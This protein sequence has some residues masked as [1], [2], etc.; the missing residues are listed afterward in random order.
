MKILLLSNKSPWPPKDG[1]SAA[2][3]SM[4]MALSEAGASVTV[5]AVNPRKHHVNPD[6]VPGSLSDKAKIYHVDLNTNLKPLNLLSNL[7]FSRL[8]YNL[9]RFSSSAF[10]KILSSV[11]KEEFDIIQFEGLSVVQYYNQVKSRSKGKSVFR[12]HNIESRIWSGLADETK[13]PLKK[14]YFRILSKRLE[15]YERRVITQFDALMPITGNDESWFK[16]AGY[17]GFSV[18]IPSAVTCE[19]ADFLAEND[20]SVFY[21]GA[22]DWLPNIYGLKWFI[23]RVWPEIIKRDPLAAFHIAGRN[24]SAK[25]EKLF[26]KKGIIYH[27]EVESSLSFIKKYSVMVVPLFSGSGLRIKII[28]GMGCGKSI[29]ATPTAAEG[30]DFEDKKNIFIASDPDQFSQNVSELLNNDNIRH[31]TGRHAIENVRK[32]Y[33]ILATA[34]SLLKFYSKLS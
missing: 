20:H 26:M 6:A 27:G 22:L 30:I 29:V 2:T 12:P 18:V 5:L 10:R 9:T 3:L 33:N 23:D 4:I 14:F 15:N 24:A 16:S 31:E 21:I 11:L 1:G 34:E 17:S 19:N 13:N 7:L 32:N 8:P 25:T 28:E